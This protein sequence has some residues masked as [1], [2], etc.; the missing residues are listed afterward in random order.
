MTTLCSS[1]SKD[2]VLTPDLLRES[3]L[4][5]RKNLT[6]SCLTAS[7]L[8]RY[9]PITPGNRMQDSLSLLADEDGRREE[10]GATGG[11]EVDDSSCIAP[12]SQ[13]QT[14]A[15]VSSGAHWAWLE[16]RKNFNFRV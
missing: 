4:F 14:A 5:P 16:D 13:A 12:S 3:A 9:A 1:F 10:R 15:T 8:V 7:V 11:S 2:R 6:P